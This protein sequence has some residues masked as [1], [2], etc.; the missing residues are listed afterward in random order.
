MN[1]STR[2]DN[3]RWEERFVRLINLQFTVVFHRLE[4]LFLE[5]FASDLGSERIIEAVIPDEGNGMGRLFAQAR[6]KRFQEPS[7]QDPVYSLPLSSS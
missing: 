7:H 5:P 2:G 4:I 3:C 6:S 1:Y